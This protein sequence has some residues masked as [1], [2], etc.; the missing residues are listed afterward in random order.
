MKLRVLPILPMLLAAASAVAQ[1]P[2]AA[3]APEATAVPAGPEEPPPQGTLL[4]QPY[5]ALQALDKVTARVQR[6][7][8]KVGESVAFGTLTIK[9]DAC[10]KAPPENSPEAAAFLE[11][12]DTKP[13]GDPQTVFSG[14]MFQSSPAISAM[15]H[16]VYDIWVVDCVKAAS[17]PST[18]VQ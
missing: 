15:D 17:A 14:W 8:V 10:R 16:A 11:I 7:T 2:P 3:Q 5:A 18:P 4:D 6:L 9:V 12:T 13:G 1:A